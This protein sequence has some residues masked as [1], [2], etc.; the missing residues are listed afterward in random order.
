LNKDSGLKI[1]RYPCCGYR[2]TQTLAEHSRWW[3]SL[4]ERPGEAEEHRCAY[5]ERPSKVLKDALV[6]NLDRCPLRSSACGDASH[7][8]VCRGGAVGREGLTCSIE[9]N[10][11]VA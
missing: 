7:G 1:K 10:G 11:D 2:N 8:M 3:E 6:D 5:Y 4:G 9:N